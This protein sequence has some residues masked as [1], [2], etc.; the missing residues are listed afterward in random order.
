MLDAVSHAHESTTMKTL[1]IAVLFTGSFL[2]LAGEISDYHLKHTPDNLSVAEVR[3]P[4]EVASTNHGIT[5]I[6]IERSGCYGDCPIY[7]FIAKNDGTVRYKGEKYVERTVPR[8][9]TGILKHSRYNGVQYVERTGEFT[10]TIP[11]WYFHR[12]AE[13]IKD[14]AYTELQDDYT[15]LVSDNSTTY[16]MV[17]MNGKRK[18][19][20]NYAN[21]GPTK[22]W[23]IEQLIDDLMAETKWDGSQKAPDKK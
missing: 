18:T 15:R 22:L 6:G 20:S 4:Y 5:E 12:L 10:G 23:A 9:V 2:S 11:V 19:V 16:T 7:T 1:M 17:V 8:T 14:L 21:A 13:F 3:G